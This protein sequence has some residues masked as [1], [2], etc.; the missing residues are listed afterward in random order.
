MSRVHLI[1][2]G[3]RSGK[4]GYAQRL[5]ESLPGLRAFIATCPVVDEEMR[6][7]ILKHQLARA[8]GTWQT[9]EEPLDLAR[10]IAARTDIPV[11]LV[12]C[13][14]LWINNLMYAAEQ[15]H[16]PPVGEEQVAARTREILAACA[17]RGGTILFVTNE[18]GMGIVPENA[19]ARRYRDLV[20]RCNQTLAA[21]ANAV[22]LV[23]C[24]IPLHLKG[25]PDELA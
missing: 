5:A 8:A 16:Q 7:R 10:V 23:T 2:G 11:L 20:G 21:G 14:T 25:S 19:L 22:T 24:G 1:T 18:V 6:Q 12:D 15:A 9:I 17:Q 3:S 4:S 13:L